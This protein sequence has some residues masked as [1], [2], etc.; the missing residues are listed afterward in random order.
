M[1]TLFTRRVSPILLIGLLSIVG[2]KKD[3]I[4]PV[5]P[6]NNKTKSVNDITGAPTPGLD[7]ENISFMPGPANA[8]PIPV[9]WQGGLGGAKIDDDI[10][11][12][13]H[14]ANGWELVYNTFNTTSRLDPLYFMLYNKYRGVVRT[15][16]YI[17]PGSNYPSSNLVHFLNLRGTGASNSPILNFAAQEI[18][19]IATKSQSASQIQPYK[20]STTGSWYAAEFE[21]AYDQSTAQ[22]PY[23]QVRL[24][25]LINPNSIAGISLNGT[26]TGTLDGTIT[27]TSSGSNFFSNALGG[28]ISGGAKVVGD[29]LKNKSILTFLPQS[30]KKSLIDAGTNGVA[31][32][33][34]GFLNGILGGTSTTTTQKVN[35]KINTNISLSGTATVESQ[36]YDNI[37]SLTGTQNVMA[38]LPYYPNYPSPMGVF[39]ISAKPVINRTVTTTQIDDGTPA[40]LYQIDQDYAINESSYQLIFNPAVTAIANIVNIRKEV[41]ILGFPMSGEVQQIQGGPEQIGDK[42]VYAAF[43]FQRIAPRRFPATV[44]GLAVRITFDVVPKDGSPKCTI[45]KTFAATENDL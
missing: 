36:L 26:Q 42:T 27:N 32:L 20:V 41:I 45:V 31:G 1:K 43:G 21:L 11:F 22:T 30:I 18:V 3:L 23:D 6:E 37:F 19:D 9:P 33:V 4:K 29:S 2:C 13:Y 25:W 16:F 44:G 35:L 15:Y 5:V 40:T 28:L 34:K 14:K 12:D 10:I 24:D 8:T 39:Y 38:T 17:S 7:W